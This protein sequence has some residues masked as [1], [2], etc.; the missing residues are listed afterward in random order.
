MFLFAKQLLQFLIMSTMTTMKCLGKE[1]LFSKELVKKAKGGGPFYG[2]IRGKKK[3][4][5]G[6]SIIDRISPSEMSD[7]FIFFSFKA[8]FFIE[9][10]LNDFSSSKIKF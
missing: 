6:W 10:V 7:S 9:F 1:H 8:K 4:I 2:L 3:K 5:H